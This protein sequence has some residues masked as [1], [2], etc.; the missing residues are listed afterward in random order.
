MDSGSLSPTEMVA[1]IL[2]VAVEENLIMGLVEWVW[3]LRGWREKEEES[4]E[5]GIWEVLAVEREKAFGDE[6]S[7]ERVKDAAAAVAAAIVISLREIG[8]LCVCWR[9]EE[10]E[11]LFV[12]LVW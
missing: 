9:R 12:C 8:G 3:S 10:I 2:E 5:E 7:L 6:R 4:V 1:E 11:R